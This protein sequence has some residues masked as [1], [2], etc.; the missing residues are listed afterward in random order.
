VESHRSTLFPTTKSLVINQLM[1]VMH[2]HKNCL[3]W[4]ST[5]EPT[6]HLFNDH[7]SF[8]FLTLIPFQMLQWKFILFHYNKKYIFFRSHN[9]L[10]SQIRNKHDYV[11]HHLPILKFKIHLWPPS[12]LANGFKIPHMSLSSCITL[13]IE[14]Q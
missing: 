14:S 12:G 7:S 11:K 8:H 13:Y 3:K 1:K 6:K 4:L 10:L 2:W 5:L 9:C